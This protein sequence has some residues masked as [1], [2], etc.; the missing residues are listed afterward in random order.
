MSVLERNKNWLIEKNK[1]QN[2][3]R[4]QNYENEVKNCTFFPEFFTKSKNI[5]LK[6]SSTCDNL[7]TPLKN[8]SK[9]QMDSFHKLLKT[10][11]YKKLNDLKKNYHNI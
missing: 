7:R 3:Q 4:K 8:T 1:K 10:G 11:S 2:I 6:R 9:S 5:N